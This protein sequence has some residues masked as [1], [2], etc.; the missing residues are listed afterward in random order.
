MHAPD[1]LFIGEATA[2]LDEP[3]EASLYNLLQQH[4]PAAT[5]ISIGHRGTLSTFHRRHLSS[6][7]DGTCS[8]SAGSPFIKGLL[9]ANSV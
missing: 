4:L 7:R 9:S 1:Y 2:S 3:A 5:I 6:A 8:A